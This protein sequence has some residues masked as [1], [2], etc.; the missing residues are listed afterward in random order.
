M[1]AQGLGVV[2]NP[3]RGGFGGTQG[4]DAKQIGQG[5]VVDA[6]ALGDRQEPDQLEPVQ[7]LGAGLVPVHLRQPA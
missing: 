3:H 6:D 4:V 7:S 2:L 5:A 1:P